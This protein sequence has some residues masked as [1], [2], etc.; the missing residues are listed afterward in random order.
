MLEV[1]IMSE[2]EMV[3]V[4]RASEDSASEAYEDLYG[5]DSNSDVMNVKITKHS[6]FTNL[7]SPIRQVEH[8]NRE[9]LRK[10]FDD[11]ILQDMK[12]VKDYNT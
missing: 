10:V 7:S 9:L 5:D 8:E 11:L 6:P 1:A 12:D 4:E 2:F 3:I